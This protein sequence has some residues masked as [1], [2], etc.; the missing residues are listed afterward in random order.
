V[1]RQQAA[2]ASVFE[3]DRLSYEFWQTWARR[4]SPV[5][6]ANDPTGLN[7]NWLANAWAAYES[8]YVA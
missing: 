8:S 4:W 2:G 6:A 5:G 1:Q 3:G 7:K